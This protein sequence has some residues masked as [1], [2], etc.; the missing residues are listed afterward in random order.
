[1]TGH[2]RRRGKQSFELKY[3]A[4]PDPVTGR[5][6]IRYV[7]FKG[8]KRGAEIE[9]ARLISSKANGT[10]VDVKKTTVAEFLE[11]WDRDWASS[12]VEGKTIERY[13]ELIELYIKRHIG[14][15]RIQKLRPVHLNELYAKLL[16][17]GG[18]AGRALAPRTVGHVHRLLHRSLGHAATWGVVLQNVAS[19]VNPPKVPDTELTILTESQIG[20]VLERL[21]GRTLRP[22]VSFLLGTG[23]R[24]GE[25]LAVRWRDIDWDNGR[26]RIE[27]SVEQ[28][29]KGGLRFK[30]PKTKNSRRNISISP[31]LLSELKA[32]RTRQHERRLTLGLGKAPE[33]SLV[34]ALWDGSTR[35]PH[36]LTQKFS[37]AMDVLK[38]DCTLH[39][40]RHTH[41]S[42]L[43]AA[44]LDIL[45]I[46]R[47][48]GHASAAITLRIYGHLFANTD[49]R[50]ADIMELAFAKVRTEEERLANIGG[51]NLVA[52]SSVTP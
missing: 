35:A 31:W 2:V 10:D 25:V 12:N 11:R 26:V 37:L 18:K 39:A 28:T 51:G 34:F 27:R 32:H 21:N 36:W 33:E 23:C 24:R 7:S 49:A 50:A 5:R 44:G 30:S 13:R 40:L 38:I 14:E 22:I 47:R 8:S 29:K 20:T 19:V 46:S 6:R 3:D 45:T 4:D 42:Q 41:V 15:V 17:E 1:M 16:R 52:I 43:I 48:L 9:L